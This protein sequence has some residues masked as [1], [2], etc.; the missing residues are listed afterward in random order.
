[1]PNRART[2][3]DRELWS[4]WTLDG[5]PASR[6]RKTPAPAARRDGIARI[7][8]TGEAR[9]VDAGLFLEAMTIYRVSGSLSYKTMA[10]LEAASRST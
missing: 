2:P 6:S 10:K 7:R 1:M 5:L 8:P 3:Y 9:W 4:R